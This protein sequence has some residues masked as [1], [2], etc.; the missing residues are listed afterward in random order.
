MRNSKNLSNFVVHF[1]GLMGLSDMQEATNIQKE[2][3][4]GWYSAIYFLGIGGIGMSALARYY[5]TKGF[6]VA[7][8]D[9]TSS[10]LT[11]E[12]ERLG[13]TISYEDDV[14]TIPEAFD[15]AHLTLVVRTPAV[16]EDSPIY[17]HFIANGFTIHKRARVL[18]DITKQRHMKALC[19]AGT[20]GKTTTSTM[21]AH[22]LYQ[23]EIGT[24]AFLGGISKNY[25]SNL[26]VQPESN[27]VVVEADEFDRSFHELL[28]TMAVVTSTDPDHLDIYGTVE[29][30][31]ES[32]TK[33]TSLIEPGGVLLKKKGIVLETR[34]Q[35]GVKEYTY[36]VVDGNENEDLP[37]FYASN[38]VIRNEQIYFDFH[39]K[40]MTI[41]KV[42]LGVPVWVNIENAVAAMAIAW[43]NGVS[44]KELYLGIQSFAGTVRR[45]NILSKSERAV[46]IDDYAHHPE[47][48]RQS[49]QS[50]K[51]LYST[52]K[53]VG[54]FQP[55]LFSR[56]RDFYKEFA[57][58]LSL[59][60]TVILLPIYPAREEPIEGVTSGLIL[61]N[62]D[63]KYKLLCQKEELCDKVKKIVETAKYPVAVVTLGAGDIDRLLPEIKSAIEEID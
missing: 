1:Y 41:E 48:L 20:H 47:E 6:P 8:Y 34:L 33:F 29:A 42:Q 63:V 28:P 50:I 62:L 46:L 25:G 56:T 51:R 60:D 36:G 4:S 9:R 15:N 43:L 39:A 27:L 16:P 59:L 38:I 53:L 24:N 44:E 14:R 55:H 54:I 17:Q 19:V 18:G 22:L 31:R 35:K 13:I 26:L 11:K 32:F 10:A 3:P 49:V 61:E 5:V 52:R 37:D 57:E 12:L 30:Y 45:F 7:G 2:Q 23:S 58:A 21:L 40:Q